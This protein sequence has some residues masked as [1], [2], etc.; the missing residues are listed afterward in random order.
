MKG[1]CHESDHPGYV[2]VLVE[3]DSVMSAV[4]F[5]ASSM[6][7]LLIK[8]RSTSASSIAI[9]PA[10]QASLQ[11][12]ASRSSSGREPSQ[13]EKVIRRLYSKGRTP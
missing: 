13:S 9:A 1:A 4:A 8:P 5:F 10:F 6:Y 11:A 7:A 12:S 2:V 3:M